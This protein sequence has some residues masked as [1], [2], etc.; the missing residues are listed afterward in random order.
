MGL[1][2][3]DSGKTHVTPKQMINILKKHLNKIWQ[4]SVPVRQMSRAG[5][6]FPSP[7]RVAL[8]LVT[9]VTERTET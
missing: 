1:F 4:V 6:E 7:L 3:G 8:R 9:A 5:I 2:D